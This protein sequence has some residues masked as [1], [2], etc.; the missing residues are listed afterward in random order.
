MLSVTSSVH[1][2]S[3]TLNEMRLLQ[4]HVLTLRA[5]HVSRVS[6]PRQH[7]RDTACQCSRGKGSGQIT[8]R[9]GRWQRGGTTYA[10][11]DLQEFAD[12]QQ[13]T[14]HAIRSY[15]NVCRSSSN[16]V[17]TGFDHVR[18][19]VRMSAFRDPVAC[20]RIM[21]KFLAFYFIR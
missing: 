12:S 17:S 9:S 2:K 16:Y 15:E 7:A 8:A 5:R 3:H 1:R 21:H 14:H 6:W 13:F 19:L 10:F 4:Q 11:G 20:E 18:R